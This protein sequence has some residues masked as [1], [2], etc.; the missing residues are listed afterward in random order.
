MDKKEIAQ[1]FEEI[2][3]LLEMK[4]ENPFRVRAYR[5]AARSLLNSDKNLKEQIRDG[6]LTDLEGIGPDLA[7]KI[8]TLVET[9][10]LPFYEKLKKSVPEG[11]MALRQLRG[12]GPKKLKILYEKLKIHSLTALKKACEEGKLSKLPGFGAKTEQNFLDAFSRKE[13]YQKRHLWWSAMER[14]APLLEKLRQFKGVKQA[15]IAGSLRRKLETV[16]DLDLLVAAA[17]PKSVMKWFTTQ[18]EVEKVLALGDT[19]S[20]VLLEG[21]LQV[22]LRIVPDKEFGFAL[23]Y[24]TGSK[25][26]NIK[27]REKA[28]KMDWSLSE[29]GFEPLDKKQTPLSLPA[30]PSEADVHKALDLAYMPPEIRENMG[31]IEAAAKGKIPL[32]VQESDLRGTFHNHTTAS[33]GRNTLKEMVLA[34]E[35]R[36]WEYFGISD[37][38]KSSFQAN[39][40]SEE[41]LLAQIEEIHKINAS[42]TYK[43]HLFAGT[44]CDILANGELDFPNSLLKQ[45]DFVIISIHN[46][47]TQDEKTITCRMIKA[48]EHP[49]ST[50]V[51]HLTSRLLLRR[52]G[53]RV[54][55]PKIIDACIANEKIIEINGQPQRLDMDWRFWHKASERGLLTCINTDA[56][57]MKDLAYTLSGIHVAKKGWLEKRHVFNTRPLRE[58]QKYLKN[59]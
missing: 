28:R 25:E 35:K 48:I 52:E 46:A 6:T 30:N 47:L 12:L 15:E 21:G 33:D 23:I 53:T 40:L 31:E 38:S 26:H 51:G 42:K 19:K 54:N 57:S 49:F 8:A 37:H 4:D 3:L 44:E 16:G 27:L 34:A 56:H 36:G 39:G 13:S 22:D 59:I 32:F 9:G 7:K 14:A 43:L 1:I 20:T 10:S 55:I 5:N 45:L 29:Y 2:A 58:I 17:S 24:F 50:M 11:L 41:R 18:P